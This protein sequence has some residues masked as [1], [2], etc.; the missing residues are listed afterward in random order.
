[1]GAMNQD[2][3]PIK[4]LQWLQEN[5]VNFQIRTFYDQGFGMFIGDD[6]NGY[7]DHAWFDSLQEG[8]DWLLKRSLEIYPELH[9]PT[10]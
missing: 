6:V 8:V 5:E 10:P 3:Q 4:N 2:W 1:M 7:K 9:L